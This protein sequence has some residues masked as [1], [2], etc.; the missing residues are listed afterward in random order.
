MP[1]INKSG[2]PAECSGCDAKAEKGQDVIKTRIDNWDPR[3]R[4]GDV[5][6]AQCGKYIRA[7]NT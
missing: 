6:C 7:L 1:M 2:I 3:S 5:V 4:E